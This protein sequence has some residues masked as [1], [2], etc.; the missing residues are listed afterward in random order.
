MKLVAFIKTKLN[1]VRIAE[2]ENRKQLDSKFTLSPR[3]LENPFS[4]S[5]RLLAAGVGR[6]GESPRVCRGKRG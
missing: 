1:P 6:G 4:V 5:N 3:L 2:G